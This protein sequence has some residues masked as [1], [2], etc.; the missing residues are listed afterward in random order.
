MRYFWKKKGAK[1]DRE[2]ERE[3]ERQMERGE[4]FVTEG[5]DNKT[6]SLYNF[7]FFDF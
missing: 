6:L 7:F 4:K 3:I 2:K 1:I 5:E